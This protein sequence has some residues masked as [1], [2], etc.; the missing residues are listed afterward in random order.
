MP[1]S[2]R[3][4]LAI[5]LPK[6]NKE[7]IL[8]IIERYQ[9]LTKS[10]IK[11]V[12]RE[13]LHITIKFLG[14][15]DPDHTPNLKDCIQA[16]LQKIPKFDLRIDRLGAFPNSSK[17][18]EIWLG[19]TCPPNLIQIHQY[20][21]DC[22]TQLGYEKDDRSFSP[23]LTIGR[24]RRDV[25]YSGI[26]EIGQVLSNIHFEFQTEF[27]A[28]KVTFFKSELSREGPKYTTLFEVSLSQ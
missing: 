27:T 16:N 19:F 26:K 14:E 23:H 21:E 20:I 15:F 24:I 3:S 13:N 25:S 11:W 5:D 2:I 12:S 7:E 28:E 8:E 1:Q 9:K 18:K 10:G 17:P 22:I 6:S 4:F